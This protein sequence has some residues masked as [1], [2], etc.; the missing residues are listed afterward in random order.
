MF[1]F[2]GGSDERVVYYSDQRPTSSLGA[3]K[4]G[5]ITRICASKAW[6]KEILKNM[7]IPSQ[8]SI[9]G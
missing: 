7:N 4:L 1:F 5:K 6:D 8:S 2:V 9:H 3:R